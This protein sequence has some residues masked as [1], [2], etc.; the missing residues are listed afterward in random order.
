MGAHIDGFIG[1]VAHT[2]VVSDKH[3]AEMEPLSGEQAKVFKAAHQAAELCARAVKPG[4]EVSCVFW[5]EGLFFVVF[6]V[7]QI[8]SHLM[9][10]LTL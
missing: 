4:E 2:V 5:D 3:A 8:H 1:V 7:G 6:Y 10:F 9:L